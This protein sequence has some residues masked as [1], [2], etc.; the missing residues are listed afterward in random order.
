MKNEGRFLIQAKM[1]V[2]RILTL[3]C[4]RPLEMLASINQKC[5]N[6][7]GWACKKEYEIS[8]CQMWRGSRAGTAGWAWVFTSS[9][10]WNP[11]RTTLLMKKLCLCRALG[12]KKGLSLG[13]ISNPRLCLFRFWSSNLFYMFSV[14]D[15]KLKN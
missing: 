4:H 9:R 13:M 10:G 1:V 15:L 3:S 12:G 7:C 14:G 8:R 6:V 5:L 11:V 2:W